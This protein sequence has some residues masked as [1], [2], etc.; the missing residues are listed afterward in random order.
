MPDPQYTTAYLHDGRQLTFPKGTDPAVIQATVKKVLAGG[1]PDP[2]P[3][4]KLGPDASSIVRPLWE[5]T[6]GIVTG[7]PDL[8]YTAGNYI[9]KLLGIPQAE[10]P[11]QI[12]QRGI[13][14]V[15]TEPT[16][17]T[18][19]LEEFIN[20][21]LVGGLGGPKLPRT[22]S[23]GPIAQRL[24]R[25]GVV[26]TPGQ[27]AAEKSGQLS[28][29]G[30]FVEEK[31]AALHPSVANAR[32]RA[33]EA[34]NRAKL[35]E[36][37]RVMGSKEV[38]SSITNLREANQYVY[39][40]LANR[41]AAAYSKTSITLGGKTP[42]DAALLKARS[43][44]QE[45]AAGAGSPLGEAEVR[46]LKH[47]INSEIVGKFTTAGKASGE[48]IKNIENLLRTEAEKLEGSEDYA[49]RQ[50]AATLQEIRDGFKQ[51]VLQQNPKSGAELDRIDEAYARY[52]LSERSSL[53]APTKSGAYT[54]GQ[55][56]AAVKAR[57]PSKDKG[58]FGRGTAQGQREA[59]E[60]Q[61]VLGNKEPNSGTPAGMA[62][63]TA[64]GAGGGG[65]AGSGN[66]AGIIPLLAALGPMGV[67]SEP[68]MKWLQ[69]RAMNADPEL[70]SSL[71]I[72]GG[73]QQAPN[74]IAGG[75]R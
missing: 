18:G 65:M 64:L 20:S 42:L 30:A 19:K 38:P 71:G 17:K 70:L 47:I 53:A 15:T 12:V 41:Y 28:K 32:G 67:Y 48:T 7:L 1:K 46:Q 22:P 66:P 9:N 51:T 33:T 4:G 45:N 49:K 52:K 11:G 3:T 8:A 6:T 14:Q 72:V 59:E 2:V 35:N 43:L 39:Q 10:S 60:T 62:L 26:T 25:E 16:T 31:L 5:G 61:K 27:R 68:I 55:R 73:A 50:L 75:A 57:D 40:E 56:I 13:D 74:P 36:A 29:L 37:L 63:L 21:A 24:A 34:W 54:P 69:S 58:A 44:Y 23:A